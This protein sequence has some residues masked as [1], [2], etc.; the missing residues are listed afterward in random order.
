MEYES[1]FLKEY[2]VTK[3][4]PSPCNKLHESV[5]LICRTNRRQWRVS[6]PGT[7]RKTITGFIKNQKDWRVLRLQTL[8]AGVVGATPEIPWNEP[9]I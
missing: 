5:R 4:A 8:K 6:Q 2:T 9:H 7:K 1:M 3:F